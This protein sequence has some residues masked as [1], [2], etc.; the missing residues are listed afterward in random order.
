MADAGNG[1]EERVEGLQIVNTG[2]PPWQ[3]GVA[4][5]TVRLKNTGLSKAKLLDANGYAVKDVSV[6]REGGEVV[7]ELPAET[8]Y[9]VVQ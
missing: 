8:M 7:I 1:K 4:K 9:L 3:V 2:T 6:K 5:A